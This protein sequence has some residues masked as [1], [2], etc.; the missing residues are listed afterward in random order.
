MAATPWLG[1][2]PADNERLAAWALSRIAATGAEDACVDAVIDIVYAARD[3]EADL[4]GRFGSGVV[5]EPATR[6]PER[7]QSFH[8][9]GISPLRLRE[10]DSDEP[11]AVL[12]DPA[13]LL[14]GIGT[15]TQASRSQEGIDLT[16]TAHPDFADPTDPWLPPG[17]HSLTVQLDPDTG[18]LRSAALHDEQGTLA[19]AQVSDL[20]V[21]DAPPSTQAGEILAR[22]ARTLLEPTRLTAEVHIETD[23]HEDLSITSVPASRSWT[24]LVDE[25]TLTMTGDYAPDRTSPAAARLA[26][27][28]TPARIVSHLANV[29]PTSPHSLQATVRPLRTFPFSAWAPD[30][31]LTCHFTVDPETGV[32]VRAAA[33]ARGR[34]VFRHTVTAL[35]PDGHTYSP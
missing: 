3:T 5:G 9:D 25:N 35:G 8:L 15:V 11:W 10:E 12:L 4:G 27:L 21:R 30:D 19:T 18:F 28:L 14:R 23:P 2:R 22:M 26:E 32:L 16:V 24:I 6:R 1:G 17:A 33:T 34:T 29:T 7:R 31:A 13:R 20:N